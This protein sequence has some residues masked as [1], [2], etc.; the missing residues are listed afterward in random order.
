MVRSPSL[1]LPPSPR[2]GRPTAAVSRRRPD[3]RWGDTGADAAGVAEGLAAGDN[4][5]SV[6]GCSAARLARDAVERLPRRP[7]GSV[8]A[9]DAF[10]TSRPAR[11]PNAFCTRQPSGE[12]TGSAHEGP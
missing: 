11:Q 1:S 8:A 12:G 3:A 7:R 5:R 4:D 2:L 10:A 9:P 6:G